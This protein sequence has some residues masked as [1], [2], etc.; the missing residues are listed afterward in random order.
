MNLKA[1][2]FRDLCSEQGFELTPAEAER[3]VQSYTNIR[4]AVEAA[5]QVNPNYFQDLENKTTEEK[6]SEIKLVGDENFGLKEYNEVR[7]VVML[8]GKLEGYVK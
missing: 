7:E 2:Q 1:K 5:L 6:L 3:Y 4:T 8:I